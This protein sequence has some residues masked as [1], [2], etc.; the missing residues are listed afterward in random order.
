MIYACHAKCCYFIFRGSAHQTAC[1][2]C[3]K[4]QI[5]PANRS[6]RAAYFRRCLIGDGGYPLPTA[7]AGTR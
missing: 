3:G 2:D 7:S 5:R 4:K 1:P 6:E